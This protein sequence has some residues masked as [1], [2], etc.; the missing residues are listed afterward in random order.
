MTVECCCFSPDNTKLI[1]CGNSFFQVW[2]YPVCSNKPM[3]EFQT[4]SHRNQLNPFSY[5]S[6]SSNN[7]WLACCITNRI[8]I[9]KLD[10]LTEQLQVLH[11]HSGRVE[12]CRFL[13][14]DSYLISYGVDNIVFLFDLSEWKIVSYVRVAYENQHIISMAVSPN[15][16]KAVCLTS[17]GRLNLIKLSGLQDNKA[18]KFPW[19]TPNQSHRQMTEQYSSRSVN[20]DHQDSEVT[21]ISMI[22]EMNEMLPS[23]IDSDDDDEGSSEEIVE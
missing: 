10:T 4:F 20:K 23:D 21:E 22:E 18:L 16:D 19:T 11:G 13:K 14:G 8:L 2:E 1:L 3:Q 12:Y 5:C 15:E 17:S 6:V 9:W 7:K